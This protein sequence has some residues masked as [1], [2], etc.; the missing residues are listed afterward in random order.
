MTLKCFQRLLSLA[1][2]S[3]PFPITTLALKVAF[4]H[5]SVYD[6]SDM[7]VREVKYNLRYTDLHMTNTIDMASI[8]RSVCESQRVE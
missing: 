4:A 6:W 8:H 2:G 5:T 1:K 3:L 7:I